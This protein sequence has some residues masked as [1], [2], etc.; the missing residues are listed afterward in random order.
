[1]VGLMATGLFA[2]AT[3]ASAETVQQDTPSPSAVCGYYETT[4]TAWYEHCGSGRIWIEVDFSGLRG[5]ELRCVGP[6]RT[7]LGGAR[8]VN[9][10]WYV[11]RTCN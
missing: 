8:A 9:N 2:T 5:N 3:P 1:M 11:G 10:A 4:A 6:G 7:D